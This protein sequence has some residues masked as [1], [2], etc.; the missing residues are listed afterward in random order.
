MS[1]IVSAANAQ[2]WVFT[3]TF[4][5]GGLDDRVAKQELAAPNRAP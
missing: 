4:T 5:T 3:G 2:R 1:K